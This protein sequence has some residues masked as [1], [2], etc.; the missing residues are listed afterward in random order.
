LRGA[1]NTT[2]V[3]IEPPLIL[4][5]F[6]NHDQALKANLQRLVVI[7][8]KYLRTYPEQWVVMEPN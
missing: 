6:E 5:D 7:L 3:F 1:H 4:A 8:E 2:S